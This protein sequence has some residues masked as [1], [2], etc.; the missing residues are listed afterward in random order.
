MKLVKALQLSALLCCLLVLPLAAQA[1]TYLVQ[2][3]V[4]TF[5]PQ[6]VTIAVGDSVRW[7]WNDGIHTVTSG[8]GPSD[9]SAGSLFDV[10]L[11]STHLY[12]IHRFLQIGDVPYFCRYD[13]ELGM[14]GFIHVRH[15]APVEAS[16]WGSVKNLY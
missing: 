7:Q 12:L 8:T 11:D 1:T 16:T 15:A 9:P 4:S 14:T 5:D 2:Q 3:V 13:F 10:P 6:E